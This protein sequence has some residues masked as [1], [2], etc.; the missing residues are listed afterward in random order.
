MRNIAT[1]N[2]NI[3]A[4][5]NSFDKL[6]TMVKRLSNKVFALERKEYVVTDSIRKHI[7][8]SLNRYEAQRK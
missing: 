7:K 3:K 6:G 8:K 2:I 5:D 4:Y 1:M